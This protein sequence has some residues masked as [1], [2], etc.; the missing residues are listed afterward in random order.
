MSVGMRGVSV[1]FHGQEHAIDVDVSSTSCN[2][3]LQLLVAALHEANLQLA[4]HT[5]KL[6][7]PKQ[8][9]LQLDKQPQ[10][11][12]YDAGIAAGMRLLLVGSLVSELSAM[13]AAQQAEL[14]L[15]LPSFEHEAAR[16]ALRSRQA[17]GKL[18][19]PAPSAA[20]RLL[21]QLAADPAISAVM[22]SHGWRVGLL[23][24][25]P[26][27]GKVGVSA[28]CVLGY[29]VNRGQE[30]S[31]RLRTDD[32]RGFRKYL[33]IRETLVHEL[34]HMEWDDHD[35]NFKALNSHLLKEVAQH[36]AAS[37]AGTRRLIDSGVVLLRSQA[38][39]VA[40]S[41]A[42]ALRVSLVGVW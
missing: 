22:E 32:L 18:P 36:E 30:I 23:S 11:T 8:G 12:L 21:H 10:M 37:A 13:Q 40:A 2:E 41:P 5:L 29:N 16:A 20:L 7:V 6:L 14:V 27:E 9:I 3:F 28:V 38:S 35:S 4:V 25:M 17:P 31:L 39:A 26:P 19:A 42:V 15:R 34:A 1:V 24:E 33:R